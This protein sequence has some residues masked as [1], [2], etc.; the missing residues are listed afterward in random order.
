MKALILDDDSTIAGFIASLL[1]KYF[2]QFDLIIQTSTAQDTAKELVTNKYDLLLF[3]VELQNGETVFDY[4]DSF[5]TS[6]AQII[7]ITGHP[8]YA[9]S[10]I[11]NN[12]IDYI[13]KPIN[14]IEFKNA[15]KKAINSIIGDVKET[16]TKTIL[17][18]QNK[19]LVVNELEQIKLIL[20]NNIEYFEAEGPYTSIYIT[21]NIVITSSKNLK[22]YEELTHNCGFF[23]I[24]NSYIANVLHIKQ[25]LK[26]NGLALEMKSGRKV[27]ISMRKKEEFFLYLNRLQV[28][29]L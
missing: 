14:I 23:R 27:D 11:K 5:N 25:I 7:F 2:P 1:K 28:N 10:A 16:N 21:D 13:L 3:D 29:H 24:H 4:I 26:K 19:N 9:I 8:D 6:A 12:A 17:D 15:I 18:S 22:Y 20:L